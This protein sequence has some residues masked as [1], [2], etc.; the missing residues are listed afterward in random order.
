MVH[1]S[2]SPENG[3]REIGEKLVYY[4]ESLSSFSFRS[5]WKCETTEKVDYEI[6]NPIICLYFLLLC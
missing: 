1:G 3:E 5:T 4:D 6:L 2:D